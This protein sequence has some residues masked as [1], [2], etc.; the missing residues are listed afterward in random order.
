MLNRF[1]RLSTCVLLTCCPA[2]LYAAEVDA[3]STPDPIKTPSG[4]KLLFS[5]HAK[6]VQIYK[7]VTENGA[8][9]WKLIAPRADLTVAQNNE[10]WKHYA[11][12]MWEAADGSKVKKLDGKEAVSMAP[13][14]NAKDNIPWLLLKVKPEGDK[15]G[16]LSSV[17]LIQR[18]NTMGGK[19]PAQL[20]TKEDAYIEVDYTATYKF[21]STA[22]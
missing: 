6:G 9:I 14:P 18:V 20:P 15:T 13:A 21:F 4:A 12:P 8:L 7:G 16:V 19:A 10:V 17:R 2:A 11:G 5:A 22:E 3:D 1:F